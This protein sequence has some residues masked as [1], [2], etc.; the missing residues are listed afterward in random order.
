MQSLGISWANPKEVVRSAMSCCPLSDLALCSAALLLSFCAFLLRGNDRQLLSC[1]P[2][3]REEL[4]S[5]LHHLLA[6]L[7]WT[8]WL[9]IPLNL[10]GAVS[11]FLSTFECSTNNNSVMSLLHSITSTRF[12]CVLQTLALLSFVV[13]LCASQYLLAWTGAA[14]LLNHMC[15]YHQDM[16]VLV[17]KM[18]TSLAM[19]HSDGPPT[20]SL[21]DGLSP[22]RRLDAVRNGEERTTLPQ[23]GSEAPGRPP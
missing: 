12:L 8:E 15:I 10:M 23:T 3:I 16:I 17:Q 1:C 2:G 4:T 18:T 9:F 13:Q 22:L 21:L 20:S 7:D 11:I 6:F 14:Y 5:S 19:E